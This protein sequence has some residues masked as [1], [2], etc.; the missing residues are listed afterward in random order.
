MLHTQREL[1][2]DGLPQFPCMFPRFP[3]LKAAL[4]QAW[5]SLPP[6]TP[7]MLA[8]L[9]TPG[10]PSQTHSPTLEREWFTNK[11]VFRQTASRSRQGRGRAQ[12]HTGSKC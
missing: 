1:G 7:T 11:Y 6:L 9:S 3:R 12:G 5:I 10:R 8:W 4:T 2:S